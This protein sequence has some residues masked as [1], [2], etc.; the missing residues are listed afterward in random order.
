MSQVGRISGPLLNANL[1]RQGVGLSFKNVL[2]D[3]PI[4]FIDSAN[5]KL[6]VNYNGTP[7]ADLYIPSQISTS[8]YLS[9]EVERP[10]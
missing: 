1:E 2:T 3:D 7:L 6:S 8:S 4:L 5:K 9:K 10:A